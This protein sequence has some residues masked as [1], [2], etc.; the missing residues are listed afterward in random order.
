MLFNNSVFLK[1]LTFN[2]DTMATGS[3]IASA[4]IG[5]FQTAQGFVRER[6]AT[7]AIEE[8]NRQ[9]LINPFRDVPISTLRSEQQ[10]EAGLSRAATSVEALQRGGTRAVFGG[11][12]RLQESNILLQSQISADLEE[13]ERRRNILIAQGEE[14]IRGI[15]ESREVAALQGLGQSL[16]VGRQ[17][18]ASGAQ[19]IVL[20]GL[21]LGSSLDNSNRPRT[22][23]LNPQQLGFSQIPVS[24]NN[25]LLNF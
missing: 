11:L 17:D 23:Q 3:A 24:S 9:E 4:G 13:Q 19:N 5:L 25:L 10:T 18:I 12:P 2:I 15:Q 21:A 16:Q 8:F 20:S 14:K 22:N 6:K 1:L 7:K